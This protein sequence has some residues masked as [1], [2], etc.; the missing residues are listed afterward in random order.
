MLLKKQG[1]GQLGSA[2]RMHFGT[3]A[4]SD[5]CVLDIP[6]AASP[7]SSATTPKHQPRSISSW[8]PRTFVELIWICRHGR[9]D[10]EAIHRTVSKTSSSST[11][12]T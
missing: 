4:R 12:S 3:L 10:D 11:S 6:W 5:C 9:H 2:A 7:R 1:F 8:R